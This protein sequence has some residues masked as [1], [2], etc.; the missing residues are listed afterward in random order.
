M[1]DLYLTREGYEKLKNELEELKKLK[2]QLSAEIGEAREQGD[3][4][5]NAGYTAARERQADVLRRIHEIDAKLKSARLLDTLAIDKSEARIGATITVVEEASGEEFTYCM[6][7]TDE[8]DPME[9]K[10]SV[11][12]PLAQGLLG[13]KPGQKVRISLP[14]GE[15]SFK[16]V[17][18]EYK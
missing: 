10:I 12:S 8:A 11:E 6:V 4:R 3:L 9:G 17:K 14:A 5:E 13:T 1:T 15:K 7:S 16:I 18:V 2:T